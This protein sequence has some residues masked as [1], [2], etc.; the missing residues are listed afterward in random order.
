M[1]NRLEGVAIASINEGD[2]EKILEFYKENGVDLNGYLGKIYL[3]RPDISVNTYF[4]CVRNGK[5][6]LFEKE[7]AEKDFEILTLDEAKALVNTNP[8]PRTMMV[9]S[10]G[11]DE[12]HRRTVLFELNGV[13]FSVS[14]KNMN[15]IESC[16]DGSF[17]SVDIF[18]WLE[19]KECPKELTEIEKI[20]QQIDDLQEKLEKLKKEY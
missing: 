8:Y 5:V 11:D 14:D 2:G 12:W 9:R 4:Y 7:K 20:Q 1:K 15:D 19:G 13:L 17:M 16:P 18:A 6:D 3:N 10:A